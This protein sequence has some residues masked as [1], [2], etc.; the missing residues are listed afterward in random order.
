MSGRRWMVG[1]VV[2]ASSALSY[3]SFYETTSERRRLAATFSS[4]HAATC[5]AYFLEMAS[6]R[7]VASTSPSLFTLYRAQTDFSGYLLVAISQSGK[8]P[9]IVEVV[10]QARARG[11]RAIAI[12]NDTDSPLAGAAEQNATA[13]NLVNAAGGMVANGLNIAHTTNITTTPTLSQVNVIS[14]SR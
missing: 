10:E 14:Q 7:P 8:T 6:G 12:T 9:E 11:A 3:A 13:L 2:V 5:G 1:V 4:D